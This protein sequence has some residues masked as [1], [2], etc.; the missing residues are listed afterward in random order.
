MVSQ[1]LGAA[2]DFS[3]CSSPADCESGHCCDL[4]D[5]GSGVFCMTP[6][7]CG[8]MRWSVCQAQWGVLENGRCVR[9]Q[10]PYRVPPEP[11]LPW[12]MEVNPFL[13]EPPVAPIP[14]KPGSP[15]LEFL[16]DH[17]VVVASTGVLAI[18]LL[19]FA[20]KRFK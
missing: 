12:N 9:G 13:E 4:T 16:S 1:G 11:K 18:T 3:L 7:Q 5:V 14:D 19:V 15:V 17:P 6:Q 2:P 8:Q 20:V 10:P